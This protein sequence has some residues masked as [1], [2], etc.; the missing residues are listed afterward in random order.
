MIP[1][2]RRAFNES[3]TTADYRDLVARLERRTGATLGFPISETPCFFPRSLMDE[4][5]ATGITLAR[6][7]LDSPAAMAA[8]TAAVPERFRGPGAGAR[9]VFLQVDFGL[10]RSDS[11]RIEPK[12]VELQAFASLYGFQLMA[13]EAYR[14][15]FHLPP[16]LRC[17][18][19]G[20]DADAYH[21]VVRDA[22]VGAHDPKTV[23]LMEIEPRRQ[24][25]WPDFVVT[26]QMWGVRAIDTADVQRQGRRLFYTREGQRVPIARI[27]NRAI[28]DELERRGVALPF[29]YRDDLEVEWAGHPAWYFQISKFSIPFL[30][31]PSVPRTWFLH[32]ID[33]LPEDRDRYLL[34]PLFSF[35]GGGIVFAPTDA[36][37]A[38]IPMAERANYI[39]QERIPFEP[40]ID[41]PDGPTQAEIRIMYVWTDA[42][43][44]QPVL[45]LIRMG[46]GK[47]MGV[48]HNKGL[49]WVG[50]S[51]GLME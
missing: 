43:G 28:P 36:Q 46:R 24:K 27:Y 2:L 20:L 42:G 41:T 51:A 11:G 48:D 14:E 40:V 5:A 8:A 44:L 21:A 30:R 32:E 25:T 31:H 19:G 33:R 13:A 22:I 37:V 23:V 50:A 17:C 29:D 4:L 3:W 10:V 35:A 15:A 12:L 7:I 39:L 9:P 38:A 47:M 6:Q 16:S 1:S 34:K 45:P 26:E 49:R 18:L